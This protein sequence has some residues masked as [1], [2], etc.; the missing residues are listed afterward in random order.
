MERSEVTAGNGVC[1]GAC[2]VLAWRE[3][4]RWERTCCVTRGERPDSKGELKHF[5]RSGQLVR[6]GSGGA[7]KPD[8]RF[9]KNFEGKHCVHVLGH[10][11][12]NRSTTKIRKR[13]PLAGAAGSF[14]APAYG[15]LRFFFFFFFF[16]RSEL[17]Y[18]GTWERKILPGRCRPKHGRNLDLRSVC[19]RRGDWWCR[20]D[21]SWN[22]CWIPVALHFRN[23]LACLRACARFSRYHHG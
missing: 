15:Q 12:S 5:H 8:G 20:A 3:A 14:D 11:S 10:G 4:T 13:T 9:R 6:D 17:P 23:E 21:R 7:F 18:P 1:R 19:W 2:R 22:S 16:F